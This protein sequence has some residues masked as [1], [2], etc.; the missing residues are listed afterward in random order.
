MIPYLEAPAW[1]LGPLTIHA[2]GVLAA[3]GVWVGSSL[4]ARAASR[5]S[6]LD[7]VPLQRAVPWALLGGVV[8]GHLLHV[9]GY[10]PELLASEGAL[11][12]LKLWDGQSSTGGAVGGLIGFAYGFRRAGARLGNYLDALALGVA[13]GWA[14]ARLGCFMAHDHPGRLT[15]FP[16]AVAFPA[17]A[18]HDLGLYDALVLGALALLLVAVARLRPAH[19][20]LMGVLAVGYSVARF[21]LDF[22]RATDIS[23]ADGRWLGLTPAQYLMVPAF[24]A[25]VVLLVRAGRARGAAP[26][27]AAAAAVVA[28]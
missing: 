16:L 22:L 13:P 2:F 20:T 8:G 11:V 7:P 6:G 9:L 14:V 27:A 17:G 4:A 28:R 21:G 12:L 10:H 26:A 23:F 24:A 19:G 18:R 1:H 5:Y 3:L 15:D 25:G